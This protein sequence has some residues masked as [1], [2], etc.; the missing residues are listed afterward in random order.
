MGVQTLAP[1]FKLVSKV[2]D[3]IRLRRSYDA[4]LELIYEELGEL[5]LQALKDDSHENWF[6]MGGKVET[7]V[8][9]L[10]LA[11]SVKVTE[12]LKNSPG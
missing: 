4:E 3:D 10:Q 9:E 2:H 12:V 8:A 7:L 6:R 5:A 1:L 11:F